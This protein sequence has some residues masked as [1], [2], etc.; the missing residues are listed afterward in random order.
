MELRFNHLAPATSL[1]SAVM[2]ERPRRVPLTTHLHSGSRPREILT[3]ASTHP[4][5]LADNT[6]GSIQL[7]GPIAPT[8]RM[9][10]QLG[11]MAAS[12]WPVVPEAAA[13]QPPKH[14]ATSPN[15]KVSAQRPAIS[16]RVS[17]SMGCNCKGLAK[18]EPR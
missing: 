8:L 5:L 11:P 2:R 14:L 16:M 7:K 10:L 13:W 9:P 15:F 12:Y 3:A 1:L 17:E 6:S 4:G 18:E